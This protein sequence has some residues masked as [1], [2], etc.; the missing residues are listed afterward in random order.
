VT[1]DA[2]RRTGLAQHAD[3]LAAVGA[4]EV[5]LASQVSIRVDPTSAGNAGL[6]TEPNTWVTLGDRDALWLGPDEWLVTSDA[7]PSDD[8]IHGF[9]SRL[10]QGH[11][12]LVDVSCNRAALD[13]GGDDRTRLLSAGCG[14]DLHPRSWRS[15]MC[16]QTLLANVGVLLQERDGV[17]RVFVRPSFA[18]HL[19]GWF[20]RVAADR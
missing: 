9:R 14:V 5:Q 6:P 3:V 18:G 11:R 19:I 1:A 16:A 7:E 13:L 4:R 17:T 15:G 2:R 20:A 10:A 12:S 8:V